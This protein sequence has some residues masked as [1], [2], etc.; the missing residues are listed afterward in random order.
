MEKIIKFL[1]AISDKNRL[2]IICLLFHKSGLCVCEIQEIIGLSQSTIS[3][4]L[5]K[6][7]EAE[8]ITYSKNGLWVNYSINEN[9][10]RNLQNILNLLI[11]DLKDDKKIRED[12][13]KAEKVSRLEI[14]KRNKAN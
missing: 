13:K 3:F 14:C 4:N 1:K 6:L 7:E 2:R 11:D 8:I 10:K 5:K 12:F 9:L